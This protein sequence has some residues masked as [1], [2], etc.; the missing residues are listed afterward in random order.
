MEVPTVSDGTLER[1]AAEHNNQEASRSGAK[2][3]VS[4]AGQEAGGVQ[5]RCVEAAG[6]ASCGLLP[7][8]GMSSDRK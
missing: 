7:E 6:P 1:L 2:R 4:Q 8:P 3:D 5:D